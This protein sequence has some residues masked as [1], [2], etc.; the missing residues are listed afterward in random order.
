[1]FDAQTFGPAKESD[2]ILTAFLVHDYLY[3]CGHRDDWD[4]KS[5]DIAMIDLLMQADPAL[6]NYYTKWFLTG[7]AQL[8][9]RLAWWLRIGGFHSLWWRKG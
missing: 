2:K 9:L 4:R 7:K 1:M 6:G 3:A 8:V 5:A